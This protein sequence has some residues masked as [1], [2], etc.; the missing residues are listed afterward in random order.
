MGASGSRP[1]AEACDG[2]LVDAGWRRLG[3]KTVRDNGVREVF[4]DLK[5]G[6]HYFLVMH[7]MVIHLRA[8]FVGL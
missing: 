2:S 8:I 1:A 3:W 7:G 4:G 6:R 5:E